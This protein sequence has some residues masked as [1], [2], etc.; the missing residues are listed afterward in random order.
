MILF[1]FQ[2]HSLNYILVSIAVSQQ[3][4][5]SAVFFGVMPD[6][7]GHRQGSLK[8][9]SLVQQHRTRSQFARY[10]HLGIIVSIGEDIT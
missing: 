9:G 10:S 8:A 6:M 7:S 5:S 2:C 1:Y 4:S 3:S